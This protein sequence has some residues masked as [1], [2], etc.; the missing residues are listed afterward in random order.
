[1]S[2]QHTNQRTI[3][4]T[5]HTQDFTV[6]P[7]A[8]LRDKSLSFKARGM[9]AMLLTNRDDWE[10]YAGWIQAQGTEGRE[11][12][13]SGIAELEAAGYMAHRISASEGGKF[14][15]HVWT[16]YDTAL[17]EEKRTKWCQRQNFKKIESDHQREAV[18]GK[19][20]T[21]NRKRE[22]VDGFP[23]P[24][25]YQETRTNDE[26][27]IPKGAEVPG[28]DFLPLPQPEPP[29]FPAALIR[30]AWNLRVP[31]LPKVRDLTGHRLKLAKGRAK[32]L[33]TLADWEAFFDRIE[34]SA[35]LTGKAPTARIWK[36]DIDWCL[37]PANFSKI[38]E[39]RYDNK[40]PKPTR[41][42]ERNPNQWSK[43]G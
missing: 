19:P 10:A 35:F 2:E 9:L 13:A 33:P 17:A 43:W 41:T 37:A 5:V 15:R 29:G 4:R 39:G 12:I 18:D 7:N 14:A 42:D 34:A 38:L 28:N 22:T 3:Y 11:A 1:M 24:N 30:D 16:I 21:G 8:L 20:L 26:E 6:L 32:D 23:A 25:K 31:S 27:L 36:A 40:T